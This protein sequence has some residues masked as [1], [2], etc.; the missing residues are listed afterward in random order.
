M[1]TT[2]PVD[3]HI[4]VVSGDAVIAKANTTGKRVAV[5]VES[6]GEA[7]P[8]LKLYAEA[9]G[10]SQSPFGQEVDVTQPVAVK[11]TPNPFARKREARQ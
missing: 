7:P 3:A 4:W 9:D 1:V 6:P 11:L 2:D 8:R 10:Y 5:T